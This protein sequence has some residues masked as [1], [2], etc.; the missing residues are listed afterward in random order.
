MFRDNG[1]LHRQPQQLLPSN[2]EPAGAYSMAL[3][4]VEIVQEKDFLTVLQVPLPSA[5][6]DNVPSTKTAIKALL[7]DKAMFQADMAVVR[8][9][10]ETLTGSIPAHT[11]D[12]DWGGHW[13]S[14]LQMLW[15]TP[16]RRNVEI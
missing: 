12:E 2:M 9:K 13:Y 6:E 3:S 16:Y 10:V 14:L 8:E 1:A 11:M 15:L 7:Q 4:E 5:L